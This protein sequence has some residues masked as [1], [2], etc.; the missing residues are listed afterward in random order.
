MLDQAT[1]SL[2][3]GQ[4]ARV[5]LAATL[6][7][8]FDVF[9]LDEPT[10]DLDLDGL[11]RLEAF[12]TGLDA[13]V[14]VVSHDRVFL[15]RVVTD[16]V[17]L[18]E[19][20]H[21]ARWFGGGWAAYLADR[22]VARR[23]AEEEYE[24]YRQQRQTL[25]DRARTQREWSVQ[26]VQPG[27]AG[28]Q[29]ARQVHPPLPHRQLR[30]ASPPRRRRPTRR[31]PG[32]RSSTSRGRAGTSSL[33]IAAAPRSGAVV[34]RLDGA[35]VD[36]G[37]FRLG[38]V[39]LEIGWA[40]RVA[41][42]GANGA[43]K[44]TLI[45]AILGRVELTAGERWVGPGVVVGELEQRRSQF[46]TY[47][48]LLDVVTGASGLRAEE[49]RSL[50]AK[51]GLAADHV[52][53]P[54]NT[55]S[56]GERTRAGLALFMARGVNLIV[57]DE[58]TNHLDL[59]AIEQLEQALDTFEGT[60]LLSPTTAGSWRPSG[61]TAPSAS[62]PAR[63]PRPEAEPHASPSTCTPGDA[64]WVAVPVPFSHGSWS[65]RRR[66]GR[67]ARRG[68]G[69]AAARRAGGRGADGDPARRAPGHHHH[70]HA[71]A[72]LRARRRVLLRRRA[73]RRGAGPAGPLL[74]DGH[75]D[76]DGVQRGDGGDR[77]PGTG[78]RAAAHDHHVVVRLVRDGPRDAARPR[79]TRSSARCRS[80]WTCC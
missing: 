12:V 79:C 74:R 34:A 16:V 18:D 76:G 30:A 27:P 5:S 66:A 60:V 4:A 9:L 35:V 65:Q 29:R 64:A 58:P 47:Q 72:R 39:D 61:P 38:P 56:P 51:F 53:R 33:E 73:A 52:G 25:V 46:A 14:A 55:L 40:E 19:H 24:G 44:S 71:G 69:Q 17:E 41:I 45:D 70:A 22:D 54:S 37:A 48:P 77:W 62:S 32:W 80:T 8:R 2:S 1:A 49:A 31:S 20:D 75:G 21:T 68:R 6:L 57:L 3:G 7:A 26:G 23:H 50:L 43:G 28:H 63:S 13:A 59:P 11:D 78:A 15:D 42:L 36:R 10:N 67:A